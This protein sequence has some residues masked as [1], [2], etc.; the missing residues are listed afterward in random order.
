M[1]QIKTNDEI[2]IDLKELWM[3][4]VHKLWI[5][6]LSG[7]GMGAIVFLIN[8]FAIIPKYESTT[9]I[10]VLN[11]QN[12]T[13]AITYSDLQTGT[14]LT[15]DYMT[16]VTS[17]PVTD[18]VI[19][20]L[21]LNLKYDELVH[22]IT[23]EN[24]T[25]TRILNIKVKYNDP[26]LAKQIADSVREASAIHITKVMDIDR[27]NMVEE[28]NI[29]DTPASPHIIRNTGIG[30]V[31]GIF[32]ATFTLSFIHIMDDT[33]KTP[34]DIEKYLEL[35]VLSTIPYQKDLVGAKRRREKRAI[36]KRRKMK[37][38]VKLNTV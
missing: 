33:I 12:S 5:L 16:L 18:Q 21:K 32:L 30:I 6:V 2:E 36:R 7:I 38:K 3:V 26:Y 17:R 34:D 35:S 29:P 24:P 22:M 15:K 31:L 37:E 20:E 19:S 28:A 10:Y 1:E 8:Y 25:D 14:Q 23:V 11:K 27:V 4:I 9:K 13:A